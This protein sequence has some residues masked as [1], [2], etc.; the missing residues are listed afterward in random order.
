MLFDYSE[1]EEKYNASFMPIQ[2][3]KKSQIDDIICKWVIN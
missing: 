1:L 2:I 3:L